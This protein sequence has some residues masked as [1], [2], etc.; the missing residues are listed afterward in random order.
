[1]GQPVGH[2]NRSPPRGCDR[3]LV[4]VV[5]A[6]IVVLAASAAVGQ[7]SVQVRSGVRADEVDVAAAAMLVVRFGAITRVFR[8]GLATTGAIVANQRLGRGQVGDYEL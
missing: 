2:G 8:A 3:F 6:Y 7:V 5:A 4:D 1:M